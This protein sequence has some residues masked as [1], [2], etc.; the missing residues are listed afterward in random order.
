MTTPEVILREVGTR[1]G[2]QSLATVLPTADKIA[3]CRT[4]AAA[5]CHE[6]EVCSFVPPALLPQF[7]DSEAVVS[8]ARQIPNL[9]V[10]VLVP[11]LKGAERAIAA[12]VDV[13]NFVVSVSESHNQANVRRSRD[14]SLVQFAEIAARVKALPAEIRP[15]LAS[16]LSTAFGCTIEGDVSPILRGA[17]QD[18]AAVPQRGGQDCVRRRSRR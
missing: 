8:A 11:N 17:A 7:A 16:G 5:G 9:T 12:Q 1:D 14:Q 4:E 13:I 3:W 10:A 18:G 6:I 15:R 2:L